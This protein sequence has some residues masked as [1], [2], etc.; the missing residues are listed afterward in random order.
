MRITRGLTLACFALF[1]GGCG[2]D[3]YVPGEGAR[4]YGAAGLETPRDTTGAG[5]AVEVGEATAPVTVAK[6]TTPAKRAPK[7]T[8]RPKRG[9]GRPGKYKVAKDG[10][11]NGGSITGTITLAAGDPGLKP[12]SISKDLDKCG[13]HEEHASERLVMD[14]I[15]RGVANCVVRLTDIATGKDWPEG[16]RAKDRTVFLDQKACVY[17]PHVQVCRDK[18]QLEIANSDPAEHNIHGYFNTLANTAFNVLTSVGSDPVKPGEAYLRAGMYLVKCDIHPWMNAAIHVV[19]NPYF[20]VTDKSGK[21]EI[22]DV[23]P[24]KYTLWVWHES[25]KEEAQYT[26]GA[27]S[28]YNYGPDWTETRT[29]E[30]KA[31]QATSADFTVPLP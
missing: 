1:I 13:G 25:M 9:K 22:K 30:V 19:K 23:P 16:M 7:R 15:T 14:P 18:T 24:G 2:D 28:S 10:V 4:R 20:A 26:A 8:T 29:V 17:I 3:H 27:I 12:V 21:F 5:T 31:G 11:T 6:K